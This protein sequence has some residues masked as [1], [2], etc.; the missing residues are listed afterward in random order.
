MYI[1]KVTNNINCKVYIGKTKRP[2]AERW[3]QHCNDA[4][5]KFK[6]FKLQEDIL[7]YGKDNFSV[8][9]IDIAGTDE[10]ACKKE[11]Y[12]IKKYNCLYPDG[13]NVS[14][15]GKNTGNM[16]KIINT[17]TGEVFET[18]NDAAKKYNRRI[19]AIEQ[20]L[21]KPHRTCA[22]CHWSTIK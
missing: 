21:D 20:A 11:I 18:M 5:N 13:Y 19:R 14:K 6:C 1:Y 15:G 22:G 9:Q 17:T 12:W 16:K 10:E 2:I 7:K 4:K 8:D 3:K